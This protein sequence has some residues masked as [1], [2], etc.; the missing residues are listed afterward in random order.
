[1]KIQVGASILSADFAHLS[2]ELKK[3]EKA[4]ID[5]IHLDIMDGH[6]V[7]NIT[8]GAPLVKKIRA[9]TSLSFDA[10]LMIESP[11]RFI[12]DF[13]KVG[14]DGITVHVECF[15]EL[16]PACQGWKFPKEITSLDATQIRPVLKMI[17]SA[18]KKAFVAL[19]PGTPLCINEILGEIDGVLIM[20]VN[21][22]FAGQSFNRTVLSKITAL[23]TKYQ[24][25]IQVD[26]G[27][28]DQT[29][30]EVI[31]AGANLLVTAS[32]FFNAPDKAK[33]VIGL[34]KL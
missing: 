19:N 12:N 13:I 17:K 5:S 6:F 23:R 27:V 3:C 33:A 21:P 11:A 30:P 31:K 4:G 2:D 26:G 22:G 34:K 1:M 7:P 16:R 29:A 14:V 25:D 9:Y 32:Y 24:G 8:F 28:N 15:G 18:G 20:S 10:H